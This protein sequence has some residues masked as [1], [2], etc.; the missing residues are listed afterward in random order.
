VTNA[1]SPP[2]VAVVGPT[3]AGKSD[4]AVHLALAGPG[5]WGSAGEVVNGDSMQIYRGMDIGTAKLTPGQRR[6]VP[7]HVLDVLDVREPATVADFQCWA[8]AA[9]VDCR[10]RGVVPIVVGGSA[11]YLRAVLDDFEFPGTDS[12]VRDRLERELADVGAAALHDRL[13][14]VDP[15][16]AAAILPS[17]GRRIVRALEVVEITGRPFRAALPT[18]SYAFDRIVQLGVDVPRDVLDAR[19]EQRVRRMW[20]AGLVDEVK[21]LRSA[22][23]GDGRTASLALGYR[24]V[25]SYLEGD[26]TEEQA[27][28]ETVSRTRR[29]AR[30]Q[31]SWFRRDPRIHWLPFDAPDLLARALDLVTPRDP[32]ETG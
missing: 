4:L 32:D 15:Q 27:L 20:S 25:L 14:H 12:Q 10:G 16:A 21:R 29:F 24:Q 8:R 6:R 17:N 13:A 31:D 1:D 26:C 9:I 28:S 7:H 23:L 11:L 18:H 5:A 2:V 22:G 3:A 19:I 30:R